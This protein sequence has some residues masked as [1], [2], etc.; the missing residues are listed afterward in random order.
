MGSIRGN[1]KALA[2]WPKTKEI[3]INKL[4]NIYDHTLLIWKVKPKFY[5]IYTKLYLHYLKGVFIFIKKAK[6]QKY[7]AI[8]NVT[9]WSK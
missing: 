3:M 1:I 9:N 8:K 4:I 5:I 7:I 6:R 2:F